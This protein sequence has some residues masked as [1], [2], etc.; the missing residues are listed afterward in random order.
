MNSSRETD[1]VSG[2]P[3]GIPLGACPKCG[4]CDGYLLAMGEGRTTEDTYGVCHAH[5]TFWSAQL[6][7]EDYPFSNVKAEANEFNAKL[8]L[9][10]QFASVLVDRDKEAVEAAIGRLPECQTFE[11]AKALRPKI[12]DGRR[13]ELGQR[14]NGAF[15]KHMMVLGCRLSIPAHLRNDYLPTQIAVAEEHQTQAALE[16]HNVEVRKALAGRSDLLAEWDN[17]YLRLRRE[18]PRRLQPVCPRCGCIGRDHDLYCS[19]D[20]GTVTP[21]S[22]DMVRECIRLRKSHYVDM[23]DE[24]PF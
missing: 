11:A 21:L 23:E 15:L 13:V 22:D 12:V 9:T 24:I 14:W 2:S 5:K 3:G 20:D 10:Y 17:A 6:S 7:N 1:H 8:L 16:E 4:D 18:L 19:Y